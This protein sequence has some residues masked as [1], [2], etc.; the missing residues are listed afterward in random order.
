MSEAPSRHLVAIAFR[1]PTL[2]KTRLRGALDPASVASLSLAMFTRVLDGLRLARAQADF[3]I[4]LISASAQIGDLA[5]REGLACIADAST[6]LNG[7]ARAATGWAEE[8]GYES[9]CLLPA[10]FADPRPSDFVR[11][12]RAPCRE[13]QVILVPA[14]DLGSNAVRL[15]LPTRLPFCYGPRSFMA[16]LAAA[17]E[18]GLTAVVMSLTSL[19]RDIDRPDDLRH[20]GSSLQH[21]GEGLSLGYAH[22]RP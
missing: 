3:D 16:H 5:A 20:L 14:H 10:D 15:G 12:M 4:A 17:R 8:C 1:D 7:A 9:L 6:G 21:Y 13:G 19:A 18:A 22:A 11:L 2:G